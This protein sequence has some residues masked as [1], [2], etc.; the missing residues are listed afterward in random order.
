MCSQSYGFSSSH[1]RMWELDHKEGWA[2]KECCFWTAV[3]GKTQSTLDN[4]EIKPINPPRNQP[5]IFIGRTDAKA[6]VAILWPLNMKIWLIGKDLMLGK[7]EGK[8]RRGWQRRRWLDGTTESLYMSL[9][10]LL[11]ITKFR[12]AW[13]AS[14]YGVRKSDVT[15]L[16]TEQQ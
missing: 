11:E 1:I 7:I 10:K 6:K 16:V 13:C 3:M 4:K 8:R 12:K 14:V 5:C 9:S 15:C 2:A